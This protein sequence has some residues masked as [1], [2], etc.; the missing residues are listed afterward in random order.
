MGPLEQWALRPFCAAST[1]D[2]V[3]TWAWRYAFRAPRGRAWRRVKV[4]EPASA[5]VQRHLNRRQLRGG[6]GRRR[7]TRLDEVRQ[8]RRVTAQ[9]PCDARALVVRQSQRVLDDEVQ[10]QRAR[11]LRLA[12]GGFGER[13]VGV[14]NGATA[15]L[16]HGRD[17]PRAPQRHEA[18]VQR[19]PV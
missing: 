19:R 5:L 14:G 18:S 3:W 13:A 15:Q 12:R 11:V 6:I 7:A 8:G 1:S 4:G 17:R 10:L 16:S 2:G 9:R